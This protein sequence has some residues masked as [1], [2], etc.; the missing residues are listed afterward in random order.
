MKDAMVNHVATNRNSMFKLATSTVEDQLEQ[1]IKSIETRMM[2]QRDS[3]YNCLTQGQSLFT[4][5]HR[6]NSC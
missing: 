2:A 4:I 3:I 6:I 5:S 1:L